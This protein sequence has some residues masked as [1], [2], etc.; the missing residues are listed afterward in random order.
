MADELSD[1]D[2]FDIAEDL[3]AGTASDEQVEKAKDEVQG[4]RD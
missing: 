4:K 1:D 2:V 3:A